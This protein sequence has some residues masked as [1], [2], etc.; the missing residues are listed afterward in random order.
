[1]SC[2]KTGRSHEQ[3]SSWRTVSSLPG[4][5][6]PVLA[7]ACAYQ[8]EARGRKRAGAGEGWTWR[9]REQDTHSAG[10]LGVAEVWTSQLNTLISWLCSDS[11]HS[12]Y[13]VHQSSPSRA[14][15]QKHHDPSWRVS[16]FTD[17]VVSVYFCFVMAAE[18][19]GPESDRKGVY[20][21]VCWAVSSLE[22]W[23]IRMSRGCEGSVLIEV[24]W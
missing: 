8:A 21:H 10:P 3:I 22:A 6:F 17:T 18:V 9:K 2:A 5:W 23:L 7:A 11:L 14:V 20:V 16:M 15:A 19:T 12:L 13:A 24:L 1:M 4:S